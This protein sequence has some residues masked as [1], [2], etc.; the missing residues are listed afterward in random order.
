METN[1]KKRRV[2]P[3][4]FSTWYSCKYKFFL[5]R[6]KGLRQFE[7]NVNTCF[8]NSIHSV[9][10]LY[11]KTL[12]TQSSQDALNH[13]LYEIF[14]LNFDNELKDK[15]ISITSEIHDEFCEDGKNIIIAFTNLTTRMKYFP[16]NK[17]EFINVE[18]EIILPIKN[19]IE[20]IGYIDLIL[21]D[22]FTGRYKIIDIK[23]SSQGWKS[24]QQNDISKISQILLYKAFFSK[25]Y[26][27]DIDLI[28]VEF[29]ILKRKL[30]ENYKFPQSRIQSFIP[31]NNQKEIAKYLNLF[32]EFVDE[33]FTSEGNF[34]ENSKNYLKN[35][36]DKYKNCKYC[37]HKG[38]NCFPTKEDIKKEII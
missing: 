11:I 24:S 3:S 14:K 19:N 20:F 23:T 8:G 2:S 22:K 15:K 4:Q 21:K 10:Q 18:D 27:V 17:Y 36:G 30:W 28:D 26:N 13:N 32:S 29:F 38:V 6:V 16:S 34:I 33:C 1:N 35:P 7:D 31:K 37:P 25:K 5:D 12:Y 9:I